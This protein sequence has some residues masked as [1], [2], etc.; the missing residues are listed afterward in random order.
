M[1]KYSDN[2]EKPVAQNTKQIKE[3]EKYFQRGN[4]FDFRFMAIC[5]IPLTKA[6]MHNFL[7]RDRQMQKLQTANC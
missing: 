6:K 4:W 7:Y 5:N 2:D 1:Q 3:K